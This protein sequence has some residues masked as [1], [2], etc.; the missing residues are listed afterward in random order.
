MK[1]YTSY[2]K[3]YELLEGFMAIRRFDGYQEA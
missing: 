2:E 1:R 3:A